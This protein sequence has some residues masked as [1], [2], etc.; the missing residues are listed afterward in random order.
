MENTF[1]VGS[2]YSNSGIGN[3]KFNAAFKLNVVRR[4]GMLWIW[5]VSK[6]FRK[7]IAA[8]ILKIYLVPPS[9]DDYRLPIRCKF[10]SIGQ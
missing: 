5:I 9:V 8:I 3:H 7:A 2:I 1:P 4:F 6:I 10:G